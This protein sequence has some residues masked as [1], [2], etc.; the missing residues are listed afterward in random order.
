MGLKERKKQNLTWRTHHLSIIWGTAKGSSTTNLSEA[1]ELT[2]YMQD[3]QL[4]HKPIETVALQLV[5][6][7]LQK[8]TVC[9]TKIYRI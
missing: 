4:T 2:M 3:T 6:M 7:Y 9:Q 1:S 8:F 5:R